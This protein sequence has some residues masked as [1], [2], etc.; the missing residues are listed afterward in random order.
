VHFFSASKTW[1]EALRTCGRDRAGTAPCRFKG[2][3]VALK[4]HYEDVQGCPWHGRAKSLRPELG[5]ERAYVFYA[6]V[7]GSS[8]LL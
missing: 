6:G 5:G 8:G 7:P 3:K 2:I 4:D 1:F